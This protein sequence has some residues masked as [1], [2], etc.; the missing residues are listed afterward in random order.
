MATDTTLGSPIWIDLTTPDPDAAQ[1]FYSELFGW[2]YADGGEEFGH[3]HTIDSDGVPVGG[4]MRAM[5]MD[6]TPIDGQ[7]AQW[8][9]YL[10]CD[11]IAATSQ[12]VQSNGGTVLFDAMPVGTLGQMAVYTDPGG[13][14]VGG[15]QPGDFAG[16]ELPL[17]PGTPV[18]FEAL[19][20]SYDACLDF[21]RAAFGWDVHPMGPEGGD[22]RYATHGEGDAATAGILDATFLGTQPGYWRVYF[23]VEDCDAAVARI[24]ELGGSLLDGPENSPFGRY[25]TV[26]DPH[27]GSFQIMAEPPPA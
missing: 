3:Y 16:F 2:T 15:W 20:T 10:K 1:K 18:W 17:R 5:E 6:G 8:T 22:M 19:S 12:Q 14:G 21:Y 24:S 23:A 9:I 7:P 25:A 27:G 11:D 4:L 26:T 13:A